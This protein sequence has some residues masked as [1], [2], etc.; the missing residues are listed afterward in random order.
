[1]QPQADC[2]SQRV[3]RAA[4]DKAQAIPSSKPACFELVLSML[5][6]KVLQAKIKPARCCGRTPSPVVR[7]SQ[8]GTPCIGDC[9]GVGFETA[10]TNLDLGA[11][12]KKAFVLKATEDFVRQQLAVR[13]H[14]FRDSVKRMRDFGDFLAVC[15]CRN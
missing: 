6:L 5:T 11:A 7:N 10:K 14:N 8:E 2:W 9:C 3:W 12:T 1:M 13:G 4:S 15:P